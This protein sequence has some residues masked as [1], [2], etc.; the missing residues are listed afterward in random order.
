MSRSLLLVV[1]LLL[2]GATAQAAT[3]GVTPEAEQQARRIFQNAEAHFRSGL[4]AEALAEYQAGYDIAPLPG[5]LINIA[6]CH[7]RLGDLTLARATYRKF[8][9]I[10][11]D[12][13]FVPQVKELIVEL[14]N[15][16]R[17]PEKPAESTQAAQPEQVR[18]NSKI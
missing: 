18:E 6:Q 13:P 12:S 3:P 7:R 9:L 15:L 1:V 2:A 5:F 11:P 16:A 8:I 17:D 10:A 14:D 4:L